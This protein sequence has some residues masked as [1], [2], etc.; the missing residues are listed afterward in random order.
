MSAVDARYHPCR[1]PTA[2]FPTT[3]VQDVVQKRQ[4]HQSPVETNVVHAIRQHFLRDGQDGITNP[5]GCSARVSRWTS[6]VVH[7]NTNRL[8]KRHPP[9][10][11]FPDSGERNRFQTALPL[12]R[13]SSRTNRRSSARLVVTSAAH[14]PIT[15]FMSP[16]SSSTPASS[17][18]AATTFSNDLAYGLKSP[19]EPRGKTQA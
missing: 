10:K 16:A 11:G 8:P 18:L 17:R 3:N 15:S 12:A 1:F 19:V 13:R 14:Q 7:G 6:T 5:S 2:N 9:R 4:G